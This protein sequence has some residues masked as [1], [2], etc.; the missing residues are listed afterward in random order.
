MQDKCKSCGLPKR[1]TTLSRHT[2]CGNRKCDLFAKV[3]PSPAKIE[4]R[5]REFVGVVQSLQEPEGHVNYCHITA[6]FGT[7]YA[8]I[9]ENRPGGGRS[10]HS[11]INLANGDVLKP[12]GWAG[13]ELKN[14]RSNIFADDVGASGITKYGTVYLR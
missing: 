13:P 7:K 12:A 6:S 4:D 3:D 9:I 2:V 1:M 8:R 11:F 5:V 10:V 14:P